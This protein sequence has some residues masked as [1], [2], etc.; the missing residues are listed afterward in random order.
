MGETPLSWHERRCYRC[1]EVERW[2]G[3]QFHEIRDG[4]HKESNHYHYCLGPTID[5]I[6][7]IA[8]EESEAAIA[9]ASL[10]PVVE[11]PVGREK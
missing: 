9:R 4:E 1:G 7:K 2:W 10:P 3:T 8:R 11:P 6:R 5:T